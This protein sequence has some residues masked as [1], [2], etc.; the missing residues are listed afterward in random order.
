MDYEAYLRTEH[1]RAVK[2]RMLASKKVRRCYVCRSKHDL[3][4]HHKTYK[5]LGRERLSD[6]VWLCRTCHHEAHL[7]LKVQGRKSKAALHS[8][9]KRM[10]QERRR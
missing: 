6:L 7:T 10:R 4:L 3:N 9:A 8:I 2:A 5:R 1:W